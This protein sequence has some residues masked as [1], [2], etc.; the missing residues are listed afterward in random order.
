MTNSTSYFR[1]QFGG[2]SEYSS[3]EPFA[4]DDEDDEDDEE[5]DKLPF[6]KEIMQSLINESESSVSLKHNKFKKEF[7]NCA[8][9]EIY[10]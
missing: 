2:S 1:N 7:R 3:D 5:D 6:A 9:P 8:K 4:G 10:T